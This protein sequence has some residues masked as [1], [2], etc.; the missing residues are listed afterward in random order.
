MTA[1]RRPLLT[2]CL[3]A[4]ALSRLFAAPAPDPAECFLLPISTTIFDHFPANEA[5]LSALSGDGRTLLQF[6]RSQSDVF[7]SVNITQR[8][9]LVRDGARTL[10]TDFHAS[11]FMG[12][13]Y[14]YSGP[15]WG[16]VSLPFDG[17]FALAWKLN[18][19]EVNAETVVLTLPGKMETPLPLTSPLGLSGNGAWAVGRFDQLGKTSVRRVRLSDRSFTEVISSAQAI[20]PKLR[21]ISDSGD[22]FFGQAI[23]PVTSADRQYLW[24]ATKGFSWLPAPEGFEAMSMD[25]TGTFFVGTYWRASQPEIPQLPAIWSAAEGLKTL[26]IQLPGLATTYGSGWKIS[27]DGRLIFGL[28]SSNPFQ[29]FNVVWTRDGSVFALK[30][31]I[32]GVDFAGLELTQVAAVSHDGRTIAGTAYGSDFKTQ[33]YLARIALPGEGPKVS[34]ATD[35]TGKR[36]ATFR[37]KIG[38]RYQ[39][40][41]ATTLGQWTPVGAAIPGDDAPHSVE[42][43]DS[44]ATAGFV[45][46]LVEAQ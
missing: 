29:G 31:L 38:F 16:C 15:A 23:D 10:L 2:S 39:T 26:P 33:H 24:T 18:S 30:D 36:T 13:P 8:E 40:Q 20:G 4:A 27:G 46:V 28:L 7:G 45:R 42:I 34:L 21:G 17:S 35:D 41:T 25:G 37:A 12:G 22:V 9:Y 11:N 43:P 5:T 44:G 1:F 19:T 3:L 6:C 32:R 14:T